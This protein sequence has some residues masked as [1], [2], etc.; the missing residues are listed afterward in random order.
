MNELCPVIDVYL[1]QLEAR[2]GENNER[3]RNCNNLPSD[4]QDALKVSKPRLGKFYLLPKIHKCLEN[5]PGTATEKISEVLDFHV[6]PLVGQ[7]DSIIKDSTDFLK[8]LK[9]LGHISSTAILCAILCST[10]MV[11]L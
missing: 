11:S 6:Q 7:V 9:S 1:K 10:D 3:G 8:K 5:V 4:E 2:V